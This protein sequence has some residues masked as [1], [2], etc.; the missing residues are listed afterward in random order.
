[1]GEGRLFKVWYYPV[2]GSKQ[3]LCRI[4]LRGDIE[5][6][7]KVWEAV[8]RIIKTSVIKEGVVYTSHFYGEYLFDNCAECEE[9][10]KCNHVYDCS[11]SII[12]AEEYEDFELEDIVFKDVFGFIWTY[13]AWVSNGDVYWERMTNWQALSIL[14]DLLDE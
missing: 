13:I 7:E 2:S 10:D 14:P 4:Y 12:Y 3:E 9:N 8:D 1:M 11:T 6:D 5:E